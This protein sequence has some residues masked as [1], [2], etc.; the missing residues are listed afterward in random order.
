MTSLVDLEWACVATGKVVVATADRAW[1]HKLNPRDSEDPF[2]GTM[3]SRGSYATTRQLLDGSIA[4]AKSAVESASIPPAFS[5]ERWVW[6]LAGSYHI[7]LPIPRLMKEAAKGFEKAG[8]SRLALWAA[9][10]AFEEQDHEQLALLDIQSMGYE[11]DS[12]VATLIPTA[13]MALMDYCTTC[14]LAPDPI[15]CL[16]YSYALERIAMGIGEE[17]IQ[18]IE[19]LFPPSIHATRYL[20]VHS[21]LGTELEHMEATLN[22][23]A[24]LTPQERTSVAIACYETARLCFSPPKEGYMSDEELQNILRPLKSHTHSS[25]GQF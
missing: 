8:R 12:V 1:L 11:A 25:T 2:A 9:Q 4:F 21:S 14:A 3:V 13:A 23:V 20:R 6:R 10:K 24:A 7:S 19:G 15:G 17:Y 5:Q 22:T 18:S 16:G